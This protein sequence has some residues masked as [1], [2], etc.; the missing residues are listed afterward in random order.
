M[1]VADKDR[2]LP[3]VSACGYEETAAHRFTIVVAAAHR[4]LFHST[5]ARHGLECELCVKVDPA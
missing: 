3:V 1:P 5:A 4:V 2:D